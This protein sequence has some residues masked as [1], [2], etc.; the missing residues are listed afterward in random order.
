MSA[1]TAPSPEAATP[2]FAGH[3]LHVV[4]AV[5]A[6]RW[7]PMLRQTLW[8]LAE[9]GLRVS[10]LTNDAPL[11]ESLHGTEVACHEHPYL[12]GWRT[13]RLARQLAARFQPP[14]DLVHAWGTGGLN[15]L[16]Q[17]AADTG[18]V[19]IAHALGVGAARRLRRRGPQVR[20]HTI[21]ASA[22]LA[23]APASRREPLADGTT[24]VIVPAVAPPVTPPPPKSDARTLAVL[25]VGSLAAPDRF[26]VL[27]DATAQLRTRDADVQ[28]VI[29]GDGRGASAVW[30][31]IN[32]RRI[33]DACVVLDEPGLWEKGLEG[34]DVC[35]VPERQDD[36]WL[37]P[38]MAL[39]MGKLVIASRDQV[40]EWFI[41]GRTCWQF[42]P[43]SAVELAYLLTRAIE[44]PR[45]VQETVAA[46]A[47]YF[48]AHHT[49]AALIDRLR[50]VYTLATR[51]TG[52]T[53]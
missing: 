26:D 34:A 43:G 31:R 39:A 21:L 44:Q 45:H 50:A 51:T 20:E 25:C 16:R 10:L 13:W 36:L 27:L 18:L 37:A 11:I 46:A 1:E 48:N 9:T 8:A 47:E 5:V 35:V 22:G 4:D 53:A 3:V 29:I 24:C 17:W 14:P 15:W 42:T 40:A 33:N 28:V 12:S 19:L 6:A 2:P 38:L 23:T 41:E 7:G 32:T 52:G 30:Q 49:V